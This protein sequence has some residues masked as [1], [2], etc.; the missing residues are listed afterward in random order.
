MPRRERPADIRRSEHWVRI[1][2]NEYSAALNSLV[3][4]LFK[5][6]TQD[7]IEWLSPIASD[8]YA[9]YFDEE[10]LYR[11]GVSDLR[12]PLRDFWPEGGPRWDGLAKTKSGKLI[13]VEAKAYIEEQVDYSSRAGPKSLEKIQEAL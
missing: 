9:E 13:L 6:K 8:A 1:A 7:Q 4:G 12:V 11:L 2:V 3:S 5:W 10:F